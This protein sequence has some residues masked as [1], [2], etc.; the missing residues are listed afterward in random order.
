M[1]IG[2]KEIS[3]IIVIVI[4]LVACL[5]AFFITR[6][7]EKYTGSMVGTFINKSEGRTSTIILRANGTCDISKPYFLASNCTY[8]RQDNEVI[9]SYYSVYSNKDVENSY[10]ILPD[11]NLSALGIITY[12]RQ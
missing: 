6:K 5:M 8:V 9:L 11:G 10:D 3:I 12:Y 7:E 2:K 4:I 1:D